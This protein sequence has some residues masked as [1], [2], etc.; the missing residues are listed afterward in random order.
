MTDQHPPADGPPAPTPPPYS[1]PAAPVPPAAPP[2]WPSPDAGEP[3]ATQPP[4][5][6]PYGAPQYSPPPYGAP[7]YSAP[8]YGTPPYGNATPPVPEAPAPGRQRR[9]G[10]V[11]GL[12][13][14]GVLVIGGILGIALFA[15]GGTDLRLN[16]SRCAIAADGSL[17]AAGTVGGPSGTGVTVDV[18]FVDS[19]TGEK[20]DTAS[21][22]IDLGTAVSGDDP[23]SVTGSAGEQVQGVTCN[24]TADD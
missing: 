17:S 22:S 6:P 20:V 11:V 10:L 5:A 9:T 7:Q 19:A 13:V 18:E 8:P 21:T 3:T 23:W 4:V 24:A 12:L 16:I 15:A 2:A 1:P 14:A